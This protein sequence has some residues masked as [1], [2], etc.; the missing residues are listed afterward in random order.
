[1]KSRLNLN[2]EYY[3]TK[4]LLKAKHV[5]SNISDIRNENN[6]AEITPEQCCKS[7]RIPKNCAGLCK[8]NINIDKNG[9][10][11]DGF[12]RSVSPCPEH[13]PTIEKCIAGK[14]RPK[15]TGYLISFV[16]CLCLCFIKS[17]HMKQLSY[18]NIY[19]F[20][21]RFSEGEKR[22]QESSYW[23]IYRI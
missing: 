3:F 21:D 13:W 22:R 19:S 9:T 17:Y 8:A 14:P 18:N 16:L 4:G 11:K 10:S 12:Q 1:M 20:R 7:N 5:H 2:I 6:D 15:N 23:Y